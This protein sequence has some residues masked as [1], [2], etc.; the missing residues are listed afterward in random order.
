MATPAP[1][2]NLALAFARFQE[3]LR[4]RSDELHRDGTIQRFECTF[5]LAWKALKV[6]LE[7]RGVFASSPREVIRHAGREG[8]LLDVG[9]WLDFLEKRNLSTHVYREDYAKAVENVFDAFEREVGRLLH[10]L[11]GASS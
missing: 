9:L 8:L 2:A 4:V 6:E 10:N 3:A 5:E 1:I 11:R 7:E